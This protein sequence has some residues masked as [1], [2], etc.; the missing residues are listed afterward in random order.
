[1]SNNITVSLDEKKQKLLEAIEEYKSVPGAL[2]I[3]LQKAQLIYG[4]LPLEVQ[5]I[6]SEGL[7][8]PVAE[9][10]GVVTFYSFFTLEPKGEY[11]ISVCMGTAC[12]VKGSNLI[13]EK[14]EK[15]LGVKA[16]EC[17]PDRKFSIDACRCI[18]A[19]GLA[20]VIT[21]N[22]DVYGRLEVEEIPGILAKYKEA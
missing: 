10:Y 22:E 9:V 1:M 2:M 8:V 21:I 15:V 5:K 16:G 14:I 18:G 12:Y 7:D 17:T 4:Y 13:L 20:P 11:V 3:V 6:V 19:C